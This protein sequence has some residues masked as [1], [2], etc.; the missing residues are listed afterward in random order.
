M[1]NSQSGSPGWSPK[2]A[3]P[4]M[5]TGSRSSDC[6]RRAGPTL[7][8]SP[9]SPPV[10][11]PTG[12]SP[13]AHRRPLVSR[14]RRVLAEQPDRALIPPNCRQ[15]PTATAQFRQESLH[16][17]RPPVPW[18]VVGEAGEPPH[19]GQPALDGV[20]VQIAGQ[21]LITPTN[22][23]GF[24][25]LFVRTQQG[26]ATGDEQ[27]SCR[28]RNLPRANHDHPHNKIALKRTNLA[29]KVSKVANH[30]VTGRVNDRLAMARRLGRPA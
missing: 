22:Q 18:P 14:V 10:R 24:E 4:P 5:P 23:H 16:L 1:I 2:K 11:P 8:P 21:L 15:C 12:T 13:L 25:H 3:S 30:Q 6:A 7:P 27:L 17:A 20:A 29:S 9:T 28:A 19:H 26:R